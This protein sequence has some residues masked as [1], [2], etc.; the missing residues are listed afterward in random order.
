MVLAIVGVSMML[1]LSKTLAPFKSKTIYF[2][3]INGFGQTQPTLSLSDVLLHSRN[4]NPFSLKTGN[5]IIIY[6]V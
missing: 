4:P 2:N 6:H 3:H 5:L 1:L